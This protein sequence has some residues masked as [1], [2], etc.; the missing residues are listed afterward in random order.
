M[1][2]RI[3]SGAFQQLRRLLA[4]QPTAADDGDL[5]RRFHEA[6]DLEAFA[7]IVQRYGP[8]VLGVCRRVLGD[9]H[10]AEDAFQ[11]TF[12]ILARKVGGVY[13]GRP[14]AGWLYTVAHRAALRARMGEARRRRVEERA[15][16]RNPDEP[17]A[18]WADVAP[19]LDGELG[20][21][22]EKYRLPIVLCYLHGATHEQAAQQLGWPV[23]TVRGRLARARDLLRIRLGRRGLALSAGAL[24]AVL[25]ENA[26]AGP[27]PAA[28]VGAALN[29][30]IDAG[31][32]PAA[33]AIA[34]GVLHMMVIQQIKWAAVGFL[35][36]AVLTGGIWMARP[37]G[38]APL[39]AAPLPMPTPPKPS[40]PAAVP[41][42]DEAH[43]WLSRLASLGHVVNGE[44]DREKQEAA[45]VA[46]VPRF[47]EDAVLKSFSEG[48]LKLLRPRADV[49]TG[50]LL[51]SPMLQGR[52]S[53]SVTSLTRD[54]NVFTLSSRVWT[55][56]GLYK[57]NQLSQHLDLV[58]LGDLEAGDYELRIVRDSM[59]LDLVKG[60][61]DHHHLVGRQVATLKFTV[62]KKDLTDDGKAFSLAQTDLR[63]G[64]FSREEHDRAVQSLGASTYT[65]RND[66]KEDQ[67]VGGLE[68]GTFDFAA[69]D[70]MPPA[71]RARPTL[72][73]PTANDPWYATIVGPELNSYEGMTLREIEWKDK[74]AILH[75]ELWTDSGERTKNIPFFPL[76]VVPLEK[77]VA[78]GGKVAA[79]EYAVR[80]ECTVLHAPAS[81]G[82]Y[83]PLPNGV[84]DLERRLGKSFAEHVKATITV[85]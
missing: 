67:L 48:D 20:R 16:P 17:N 33:A 4:P 69:W 63:A 45:I 43:L 68:V 49:A 15:V 14:L 38:V 81:S 65:L 41:P 82:E 26:V 11:A 32:A 24:S 29:A 19:L 31:T 74:E 77:P 61:A 78:P 12:L 2:H 46:Q 7:A 80:V 30:V 42:A 71:Q 64:E 34:E 83:R 35:A 56:N 40:G 22:P 44:K 52:D 76:L 18:D 10:R 50:V 54:K 85:R 58:P 47:T 62:S 27:V 3:F 57:R 75:I 37:G 28:L 73:E 84:K 39:A 51:V 5:L 25:A 55:D 13:R 53:A 6:G 72:K 23:G 36:V 8:L 66:V 9:A 21:L 59:H 70:K 60:R 79:G 1:S